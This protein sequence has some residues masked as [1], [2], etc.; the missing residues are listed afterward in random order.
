MAI[1]QRQKT[2]RMVQMAMLVALVVVLQLV[3]ALLTKIIPFLPFSI[4]LT[5][6]PVVVGAILFGERGGA[7]LGFFFGAVVLVNCITGLDLGGL[8][9]WSANPFLTAVICFVKGI[10]A[11]VVPAVIYKL[12]TKKHEERKLMG[13]IL[14]AVSAPIVNTALFVSGALIFFMDILKVWSG[15]QNMLLYIIVGLAGVNFL[16]EFAVNLILS[17][18]ILRII[19][20]IGKNKK[21]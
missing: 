16:F 4:T 20:I 2:L 9:L 3:S 12:I 19:G 15:G 13:V 6:V 17:P 21:Q 10:A 5:L 14:A 18:T 8:Q 7:V 11:G 1:S